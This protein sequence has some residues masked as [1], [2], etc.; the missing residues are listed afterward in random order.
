MG[1]SQVTPGEAV[2]AA[3]GGGGLRWLRGE[4]HVAEQVIGYRKRRQVTEQDLGVEPLELPPREFD[5]QG[6]WIA[7]GE[8]EAAVLAEGGRDPLGSLHALEHALI[9]MTPLVVLCD[10]RDLGGVSYSAAPGLG[11]PAVFLYD[12]YP[13]GVGITEAA[14]ARL[15]ELLADT[16]DMIAACPCEG[17]CP[18][19]V[20]SP[21]CGDGNHPLDKAGALE[22]ARHLAGRWRAGDARE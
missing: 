1:V 21:S 18:S 14:F 15:G 9:A 8:A 3:D 4:I 16:A 13:G 10:Q 20:Q 5:T 7:M 22:L 12:G 11:G 17:G 2:E 6:L 19:C